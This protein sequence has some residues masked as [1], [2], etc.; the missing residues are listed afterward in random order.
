M[1][2]P[3]DLEEN[4]K[5]Y[6]DNNKDIVF[7]I[8]KEED[9]KEKY[10]VVKES[11]LLQINKDLQDLIEHNRTESLKEAFYNLSKE[12]FQKLDETIKERLKEYI[13]Y[14]INRGY[15]C[16]IPFIVSVISKFY[17]KEDF[18]KESIET[19]FNNIINSSSDSNSEVLDGLLE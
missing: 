11:K 2:I 1:K 14:L 7:E 19:C 15:D 18:P 10:N 3:V 6:L 16:D 13:I 9:E 5:V 12:E 8:K 17:K 4:T